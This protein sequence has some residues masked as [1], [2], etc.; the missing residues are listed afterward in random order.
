MEVADRSGTESMTNRAYED[1]RADIVDGTLMPGSKLKIDALRQR[2]G[3][4]ASPIRE[5]LSLLTSTLLVERIDQRGFRVAP[6]SLEAFDQLLWTRCSIEAIALRESM[7]RGGQ[8]WQEQV[9]LANYRLSRLDRESPDAPGMT[10]PRW[11]ELH[12]AFHMT[13]LS[14]CGS[15]YIINF[16][17]ELYD[18]NVRYRL[19]SR[20]KVGPERDVTEEHSAIAD[21][22]L[23]NNPDLAVT[24]L[25]K[26]YRDTGE[27]L[28]RSLG[29]P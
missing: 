11:E 3:I 16:C 20:D 12:K 28:R 9:V 27:L 24:L 6:I 19:T 2:Y 15:T 21:A 7:L 13:L 8:P 1:I 14:A 18:H 5:A 25:E 4:G 29:E 17:S 23:D 10:N 22:V 26:H